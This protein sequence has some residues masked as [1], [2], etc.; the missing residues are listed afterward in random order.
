MNTNTG[1]TPAAGVLNARTNRSI[2]DIDWD[3]Q[4]LG[5]LA[6]THLAKL[7]GVGVGSVGWLARR[8]HIASRFAPSRTTTSPL[9][10]WQHLL[11][12]WGAE[13]AEAW[14]RECAAP[15]LV[16]A[17][18]GDLRAAGAASAAQAG[19]RPTRRSEC[20]DGPR[21]CPWLSCRYH[22]PSSC[23]LDEAAGGPRTP[24][25]VAELMGVTPQRV[26]QVLRTATQRVVANLVARLG[27]E[28]AADLLGVS[29]ATLER[30]EV[31]SCG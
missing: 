4:P 3:A 25:E 16:A 20:I 7:L 5:L 23:A 19:V 18:I 9:D 17:A 13:R 31:A 27:R 12:E 15:D 14:L 24:T 6:H 26:A 22:L 28:E 1:T 30:M 11:A 21:P 2:H 10:R 29:L 8:N